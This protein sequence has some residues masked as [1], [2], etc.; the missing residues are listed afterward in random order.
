MQGEIFLFFFKTFLIALRF[1]I[2]SVN[3]DCGEATK[4]VSPFF[5]KSFYAQTLQS[6]L[7]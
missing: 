2:E 3:L 6:Q 5:F 7:P 4:V 1:S